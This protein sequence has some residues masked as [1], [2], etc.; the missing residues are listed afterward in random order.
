MDY[1]IRPAQVDD[2]KE[3]ARLFAV[4]GHPCSASDIAARWDAWTGEGNSALVAE[5]FDGTLAGVA[6]LHMMRVLHKAQAIGRVTALVV[7]TPLQG[8]GIGRRLMAAAEAIVTEGGC[9]SMEITS[10]VDRLE[11]HA[12][13]KGIG[14]AYTSVRLNKVMPAPLPDYGVKR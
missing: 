7:D 14:Y 2:N 12:F 5:A 8:T 13:Y 1:R 11:A 10:H 9:G 6:T 3:L 4:L